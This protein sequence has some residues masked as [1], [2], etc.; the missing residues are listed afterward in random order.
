[1]LTG[2]NSPLDEKWK[3]VLDCMEVD[4]ENKNEKI[5]FNEFLTAAVD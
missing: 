1:M 2:I 3:H 5:N 4:H